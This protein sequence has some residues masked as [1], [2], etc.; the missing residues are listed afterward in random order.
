[1]GRLLHALASAS[2]P[3]ASIPTGS[4]SWR[5][6]P[7]AALVPAIVAVILDAALCLAVAVYIT[8][9]NG[10][11]DFSPLAP[12]AA[13]KTAPARAALRPPKAAACAACCSPASSSDRPTF[14]ALPSAFRR[15]SAEPG[16]AATS[17]SGAA[18]KLAPAHA[19]KTHH[20]ARTFRKALRAQAVERSA[21][22][23]E[24]PVLGLLRSVPPLCGKPPLPRQPFAHIDGKALSIAAH[25]GKCTTR[26][27]STALPVSQPPLSPLPPHVLY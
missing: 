16:Q 6:T 10:P 5:D 26:T 9:R 11:A 23:P 4:T 12:A 14:L 15:G 25:G 22:A 7:L 17:T 21:S 2:L 18:G 13:H 20:S 3:V 24:V 1:M 19:H 27:E 8:S